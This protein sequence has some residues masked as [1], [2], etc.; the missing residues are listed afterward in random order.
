MVPLSKIELLINKFGS[1][2]EL[3]FFLRQFITENKKHK[4]EQVL[5]LRT[6]HLTAVI[7]NVVD[8]H[9]SNAVIR[10]CECLGIQDVYTISNPGFK[11]AKGVLRGSGKWVTIR[12]FQKASDN[13]MQCISDLRSKGYKIAATALHS[14]SIPLSALP[15]NE[16]LA[17]CFGHERSGISKVLLEQ[18]DTVFHIPMYGF[19]ESYNISVAAAIALTDLSNRLRNSDAAWKLPEEEKQ[20]LRLEWTLKCLK[21]PESLIRSYY[22]NSGKVF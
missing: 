21:K 1:D 12:K 7:E 3:F 10:T 14:N 18:A 19:T 17:V 15:V 9:N 8:Q 16:P 6:R 4:F 11:S 13:T 20:S 5:N 2:A 22:S